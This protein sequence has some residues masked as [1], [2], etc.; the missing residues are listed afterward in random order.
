MKRVDLDQVVKQAVLNRPDDLPDVIRQ[1]FDQTYA[2]LR[3]TPVKQPAA[4]PEI[5]KERIE[6]SYHA[7]EED[8]SRR[9]RV[10][11]RKVMLA[12]AAA[13][14]IGFGIIGSGFISPTMAQTLKQIPFLQSVFKAA[15]DLGLQTA[16]E[17]GL[18]DNV[19]QSVTQHGVTLDVSKVIYD[20]A[21][22]SIGI[23]QPAPGRD[24]K[25]V[26]LFIDGMSEHFAHS[27]TNPI[28]SEDGKTVNS[29]YNFTPDWN[30]PDEFE[31]SL[32]VY[33]EDMENER[34]EFRFP[35]KKI[36]SRTLA[37]KIE[38][39][40][41][42]EKIALQ[43]IEI[44]EASTRVVLGFDHPVDE[45]DGTSYLKDLKVAVFDDR[46]I[47]LEPMG[48]ARSGTRMDNMLYNTLDQQYAPF[49]RVPKSITLRPY[50]I[51]SKAGLKEIKTKVEA[52][53]AEDAPLVLTQGQAGHL[54]VSRIEHQDDKTLLYYRS[55]GDEPFLNSGQLIIEDEAGNQ[56]HYDKKRIADPETYSFV[57]EYPALKRDEKL[58]FITKQTPAAK[59]IGEFEMTIPVTE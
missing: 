2:A 37:P 34:F 26:K 50:F 48:G 59:Y 35:V 51:E 39:Q 19:N 45:E 30:L 56:Y 55:F 28:L 25:E 27:Y 36:A 7:L 6:Q 53:P 32:H 24:I 40:R 43:K 22:L 8:P 31:L 20:G 21:R 11:F 42:E 49:Q 46:G 44:T 5:V 47:E 33:L 54:E 29:V 10:R 9:P 58:T 14:V 52:A 16:D 18:V 1:R 38:K 57:A 23:V 3:V 13:T 4:L 12:A 41:G 15:G 17:K